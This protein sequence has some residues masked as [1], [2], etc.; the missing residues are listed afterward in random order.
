[1]RI[2]F[3]SKTVFEGEN[4]VMGSIICIPYII[5]LYWA[6]IL[7]KVA[8]VVE[9]KKKNRTSTLEK[10]KGP[11]GSSALMPGPYNPAPAI[12]S[13]VNHRGQICPQRCDWFNAETL[14]THSGPRP[15]ALLSCLWW[16]GAEQPATVKRKWLISLSVK[17]K[18]LG[19]Q[20]DWIHQ[21]S[22]KWT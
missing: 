21:P 16:K 22:D 17:D 1:M 13:L 11:A 20:T 4:S 6:Y 18:G 10:Q 12:S 2:I 14:Y 7:F 5:L 8:V 15:L 3:K 19:K 9:K